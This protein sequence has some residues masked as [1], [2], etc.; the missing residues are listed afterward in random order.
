VDL[1]G[2]VDERLPPV[3][4]VGV[5]VG[6]CSWGTAAAT[7]AVTRVAFAGVPLR[8]VA[9]IEARVAGAADGVAR[10]NAVDVNDAA[11]ARVAFAG[12]RLVD[13]ASSAH[14][15]LRVLAP[16][17]DGADGADAGAF[18]RF[19]S[20]GGFGGN[21]GLDAATA[22]EEPRA[23]AGGG[24]GAD[25][26]LVGGGIF[27]AVDRGGASGGLGASAAAAA[28]S[29]LAATDLTDIATV[30]ASG[31]AATL[32]RRGGASATDC[33]G[34]GARSPKSGAAPPSLAAL[35][36]CLSGGRVSGRTF[37]GGSASGGS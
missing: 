19:F 34:D 1:A 26:G 30:P 13:G 29:C 2:A 15:A 9:F 23:L 31:L 37:S 35:A 16:R 7:L 8:S 28:A 36:G 12:A 10:F 3:A 11:V 27:A 24:L 18:L 6:V 17:L 4:V 21:G 20:R 22:L 32:G 33:F 25:G 14:A 5:V